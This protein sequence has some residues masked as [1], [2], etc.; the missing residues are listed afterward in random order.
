MA[1]KIF[2]KLYKALISFFTNFIPNKE[3]RQE[4]KKSLLM[5]QFNSKRFAFEDAAK[6]PNYLNVLAC[7]K[8][9]GPY[10]KEWIEYHRLLGVEKFYIY[11]NE[12]TDNT[13]EVLR[14]YIEK[15]IVVFD[16]FSF[17]GD[18]WPQPQRDLYTKAV[19]KYRNETKWLSI[20]DIDEFIVPLRHNSIVDFLKDF[21]SFS[22]ITI[23]Y[24]FFGF[25]GHKTKPEGLTLE[26][27]LYSIED[28]DT[29]VESVINKNTGKSILNPRAALGRI[30]EHYSPV[31]GMPVDENKAPYL[32]D[33]C[34]GG[35]TTD[36]IT[37]NHY[38]TK[39]EEE[40]SKRQLRNEWR[41][42][43]FRDAGGKDVY[44]DA[45]LRFVPKLK[46]RLGE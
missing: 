2:F 4:I 10:F 37:V 27:Y 8:N 29:G 14:P 33:P 15:G 38:W 5:A 41:L 19:Q 35:A 20:I 42:A 24:K 1:V 16:S 26:N 18:I 44:N 45:V 7:A 23:H 6:F 32:E 13:K 12:S 39:S 30:F 3:R 36:I 34:K 43:K 21:E 28:A 40:F 9:E 31:I 25:C 22:Q 46:E 17:E 11:D